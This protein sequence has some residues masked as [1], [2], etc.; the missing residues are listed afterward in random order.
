MMLKGTYWRHVVLQESP[1]WIWEITHSL[2]K[3]VS[4]ETDRISTDPLKGRASDSRTEN[5]SRRSSNILGRLL[6]VKREFVQA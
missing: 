3:V 4:R 1:V 2:P 5:V 6:K